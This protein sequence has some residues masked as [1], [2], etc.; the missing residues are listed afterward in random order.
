MCIGCAAG[1]EHGSLRGIFFALGA[2]LCGRFP[3]K[4]TTASWRWIR[5]RRRFWPAP[6]GLIATRASLNE[7]ESSQRKTAPRVRGSNLVMAVWRIFASPPFC[8]MRTF[9]LFQ[10]KGLRS[11]PKWTLI[12]PQS[13][14]PKG[15]GRR[16]TVRSESGWPLCVERGLILLRS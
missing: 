3:E 1:G 8:R 2:I 13:P 5:R 16:G 7:I 4:G 9:L 6:N 12:S 14:A 10:E 11:R 15:S